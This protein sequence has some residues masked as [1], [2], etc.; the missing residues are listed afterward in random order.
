M[1]LLITIRSTNGIG[2]ATYANRSGSDRLLLFRIS[3]GAQVLMGLRL[4]FNIG[5]SEALG[6]TVEDSRLGRI[7][8]GGCRANL[9]QG[10][11]YLRNLGNASKQFE[12]WRRVARYAVRAFNPFAKTAAIS[13]FGMKSGIL[14]YC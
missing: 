12:G 6:R 9:L 4:V 5:S 2:V 7:L 13:S 3:W 1:N 10:F 14:L 11:F 8:N